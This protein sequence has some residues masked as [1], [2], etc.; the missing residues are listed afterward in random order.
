MSIRCN[1]WIGPTASVVAAAL[2]GLP[3]IA[4]EHGDAGRGSALALQVC[5]ACHGV[6]KN[7]A[8]INPLAPPFAAIAEVRGMSAMALNVAL[9]SPHRAMPNIMLD[10]QER[11]DVVAYI[12]S[13]KSR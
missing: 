12:L 9:Q 5:M 1:R 3:S 2:S 13:L 8:S 11:A 6:R 4:Q 7:E 10:P